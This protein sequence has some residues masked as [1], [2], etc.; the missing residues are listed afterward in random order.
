MGE[1]ARLGEDRVHLLLLGVSFSDWYQGPSLTLHLLQWDAL[2]EL[3]K[4]DLLLGFL[5]RL[6]LCGSG[7]WA[8]E[9]ARDVLRIALNDGICLDKFKL[10]EQLV[11]EQVV[12]VLERQVDSSLLIL[13]L[14]SAAQTASN[15]ILRVLNVAHIDRR[16]VRRIP[17]PL[18]NRLLISNELRLINSLILAGASTEEIRRH[19]S[20]VL[21]STTI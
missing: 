21:L 12:E 14:D 15:L 9:K 8:P 4:I 18:A 5:S 1:G 13:G 16:S 17:L 6:L 7:A 19:A 20:L 2:P 10:A 11:G 3:L